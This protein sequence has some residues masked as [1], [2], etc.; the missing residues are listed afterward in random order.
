MRHS[1]IDRGTARTV[2]PVNDQTKPY[3]SIRTRRTRRP[4][5]ARRPDRAAAPRDS[6]SGRSHRRRSRPRPRVRPG[7][8]RK[9]GRRPEPAVRFVYGRDLRDGLDGAGA[10][11]AL[12]F[13]ITAPGIHST[14][15][16][17]TGPTTSAG[18]NPTA[19]YEPSTVA[20]PASADWAAVA[21][22]SHPGAC[23][24][25]QPIESD[26]PLMRTAGR[27]ERIS[28]FSILSQLRSGSPG[29]P[30]TPGRRASRNY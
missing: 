28:T 27:A 12:S 13:P 3:D 4:T 19:A 7:S 9:R 8:P 17:S 14:R 10:L 26:R 16:D 2:E 29:I 24:A 11:P 25:I 21:P 1:G 23:P 5:A 30:S 22:S 18:V 15:N 6:P 20:V